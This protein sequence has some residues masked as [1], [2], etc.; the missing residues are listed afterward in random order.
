[1]APV[2]RSF[3]LWIILPAVCILRT[4]DASGTGSGSSGR[5]KYTLREI[6]QDGEWVNAAMSEYGYD[7]SGRQNEINEMTWR[8]G[9]WIDTVLVTNDYNAQGLLRERRE[10]RCSTGLI[11]SHELYEYDG[12]GNLVRM[13]FPD[14]PWFRARGIFKTRVNPFGP[15]PV[16]TVNPYL[17]TSRIH[18]IQFTYH[19]SGL[20]DQIRYLSSADKIQNAPFST[21]KLHPLK[22]RTFLLSDYS[23]G[24]LDAYGDSLWHIPP[25][26]SEVI[27]KNQ[28]FAYQTNGNQVAAL[29]FQDPAFPGSDMDKQWDFYEIW[30]PCE[31]RTM[32]FYSKGAVSDSIHPVVLSHLNPHQRRAIFGDLL[33][34][35]LRSTAADPSMYRIRL[36]AAQDEA[37]VTR[38]Y[39]SRLEES[40]SAGSTTIP[41]NFHQYT[42]EPRF[43]T[44]YPVR[45]RP[46]IKMV[47]QFMLPADKL[48]SPSVYGFDWDHDFQWINSIGRDFQ[49]DGSGRLTKS[50]IRTW[51]WEKTDPD[52]GAW[53]DDSRHEVLYDLAGNASEIDSYVWNG[54]TGTWDF[55]ERISFV[56]EESSG[57]AQ[58]NQPAIVLANHPNPFNTHTVITFRMDRPSAASL[59]IYDTAGRLVRLAMPSQTMPASDHSYRWDGKDQDGGTVR[60]GIYIYR[61]ETESRRISGKCLFVK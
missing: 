35:W 6:R 38:Y 15:A 7:S 43:R 60:S 57:Q 26:G 16:I 56:Y 58:S 53:K 8:S 2:S 40:L 28:H 49:Y 23:D 46:L 39:S 12:N 47:E 54:E 31:T 25:S 17:L 52:N 45:N 10:K 36:E 11:L 3:F 33:G 61:L 55:R 48:D 21:E 13:S 24:I 4:G 9:A 44:D 27:T 14:A 5:L 22:S 1:M 29:G 34:F 32:W 41:G 37:V 19:A 18:E 30:H 20:L 59:K 51:E 50:T 42:Y